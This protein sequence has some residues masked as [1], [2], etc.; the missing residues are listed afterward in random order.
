MSTDDR[1]AKN[2]RLA[3]CVFYTCIDMMHVDDNVNIFCGNEITHVQRHDN[4]AETFR[5]RFV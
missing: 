1:D 4:L 3:K 2:Y 5:V